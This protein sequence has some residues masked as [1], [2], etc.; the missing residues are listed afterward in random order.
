MFCFCLFG[1]FNEPISISFILIIPCKVINL[2]HDSQSNHIATI[3]DRWTYS[4][5]IMLLIR[6]IKI[7]AYIFYSFISQNVDHFDAPLLLARAKRA[8]PMKN[9]LISNWFMSLHS[10]LWY[11]KWIDATSKWSTFTFFS[12]RLWPIETDHHTN[13]HLNTQIR[14]KLWWNWRHWWH[15]K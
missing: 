6:L 5:V 1:F 4:F 12:H 2:Y 9:A 3:V 13:F 10:P 14:W 8:I 11:R 7:G 15:D